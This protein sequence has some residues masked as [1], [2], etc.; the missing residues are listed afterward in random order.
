MYGSCPI[1]KIFTFPNCSVVRGRGG[2]EISTVIVSGAV[3]ATWHS[4]SQQ[5]C[6]GGISPHHVTNEETAAWAGKWLAQGQIRVNETPHYFWATTQR[7]PHT[8]LS[9]FLS[10]SQAFSPQHPRPFIQCEGHWESHHIYI[11]YKPMNSITFLCEAIC[12]L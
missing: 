2:N 8:S 9:L 6:K 12:L 11:N 3:R 5:P 1:L 7:P 10:S 4:L